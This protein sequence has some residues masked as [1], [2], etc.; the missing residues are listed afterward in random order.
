MNQWDQGL[1]IA[2]I[3]LGLYNMGLLY[4]MIF[5]VNQSLPQFQWISFFTFSRSVEKAHQ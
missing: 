1:L 5:R 4:F 3:V 2:F